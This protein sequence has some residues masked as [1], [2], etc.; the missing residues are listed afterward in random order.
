[1]DL[2]GG[3]SSLGSPEFLDQNQT[4]GK[5][6]NE[7]VKILLETQFLPRE[8]S[9]NSGQRTTQDFLT[10][11]P[12]LYHFIH[13]TTGGLGVGDSDKNHTNIPKC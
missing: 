6:F 12:T 4:L 2:S 7:S 9:Q 13:I 8:S 1:M 10:P 5:K 3:D 11:K